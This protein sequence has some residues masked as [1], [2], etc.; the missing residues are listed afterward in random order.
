LTD[1]PKLFGF[2]QLDLA[3]VLAISDGRYVIRD[4]GEE[5]V[6]VLETLGAPAPPRRRRRR[7]REIAPNRTPATLPLT[8]VTV[9]SASH[10][11][12]GE[13]EAGR[14][15]RDVAATETSA[16]A[17]LVASV[18][19]LN[20]ALHVGA[21]VSDDPH[22]QAF[23]PGRASA[24]RIGFGSGEQVAGGDFTSA[25]EVDV[26]AGASPRQRRAEELRPQER[27]AA[28]LGGRDRL[29]ACETLLLR[30]RADLDAGRHREAALQLRIGLD[31]LLVELPGAI[32]DPDHAEDI[33]ALAPRRNEAV[34]AA[35]AA[36]QADLTSAQLEQVEE[37]AVICERV[38]RRRRVLR[39]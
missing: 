35:A 5:H 16:D 9:V 32:D 17:L 4:E 31:A 39:G 23:T 10:P 18:A 28:V 15:L 38:I 12:A 6:L 34:A 13:E 14:W 33:A 26:R 20:R 36:L 7:A 37:L 19:L 30:A 29:D 2:A 21:V 22:P 1:D 8:R 24:V 3:G 27:L 25:V 11:F